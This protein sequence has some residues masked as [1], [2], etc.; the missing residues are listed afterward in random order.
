MKVKLIQKQIPRTVTG[1]REEVEAIARQVLLEVIENDIIRDVVRA[2]QAVE[3]HH[4]TLVHTQD[5][6]LGLVHHTKE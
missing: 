1:I 2:T 5:H 3:A 4:K 6:L